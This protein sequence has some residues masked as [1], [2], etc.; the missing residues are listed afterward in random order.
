TYTI[1][2]ISDIDSLDPAWAYD[3]IS[4]M[5][6]LNV[7]ETLISY[8]GASIQDFEP[9]IAEKVPSI[10]N[11]LI[12]KDGLTYTFPIRSG[13]KFHDAT[14]LTAEDVKYSLMRFLLL[15]RDGG[16]SSLLLEPILGWTSTRENGYAKKSAFNEAD[17]AIQIQGNNV[18]IR[19]KNPFAPFLTILAGW[20]VIVPKK[21]SMEKNDWDGTQDAWIKYNNP[22]KESSPFFDNTNG[23]GPFILE[24]WDKKN[25]E[26]ILIRNDE[27]WQSSRQSHE[28]MG[29][30]PASLKRV[31]IKGIDE[32]TTRRLMLSQGD[33]D[34]ILADRSAY[35]QLEGI[36]GVTIA[37][38]LP[39]ISLNPTV[40]FTFKINDFANPDIGS[41]KLDGRGIPPD[42]FSDPDIRKGFTYAFDYESYIREVYHNKG[43]QAASCIPKSL[44]D[45]KSGGTAYRFDLKKAEEHFK[46]AWNGR[47]WEKGFKLSVVFNSGNFARQAVGQIIKKNVESLNP[48]FQIDARGLQWSTYLDR[49]HDSKLPIFIDG[50]NADYPDAHNFAFPFLHSKGHFPIVQHYENPKA[51]ELIVKAARENRPAKR[52]EL[53]AKLI[54]IEHRDTPFF[55][56]IETVRF[57]AQRSWVKGWVHNPM[58]PAAPFGSQFYTIYKEE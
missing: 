21:W 43:F 24:R 29:R 36:A 4:G 34:V 20:G 56:T 53:Y 35:S 39:L 27:Y 41:G 9:L 19:L 52:K 33:A 46:R 44:L 25:K 15:D 16:P 31:V 28:R 49:M 14:T 38:D 54:E 11:G 55:A 58:F 51:D 6:I 42:F 12:S 23:T 30:K 40:H 22:K 37:D 5:V 50:W 17:Q 57:R 13:I 26:I 1:A 10:A 8:K 7:Y 48:K 45:I 32:F 2:M 47:V 18:V 3:S